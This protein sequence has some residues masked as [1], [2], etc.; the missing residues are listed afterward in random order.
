[1]KYI[2]VGYGGVEL[3]IIFDEI[4]DHFDMVKGSVD[5]V[6]SA[7]FVKFYP[8]KTFEVDCYGKS[9]TLKKQSRGEVDSQIILRQMVKD[10]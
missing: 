7:G 6:I 1:M 8:G 3:P 2:I 4:I 5:D 9:V 10:Y